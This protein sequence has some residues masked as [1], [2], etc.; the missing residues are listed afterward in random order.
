MRTKEI[1]TKRGMLALISCI[2]LLLCM[3]CA[4]C[5]DKSDTEGY[6]DARNGV[7]VVSEYVALEGEEV[8][9]AH[10][11]GFFIGKEGE[12]PQYLITNYHVIEDYLYYGAGMN[13]TYQAPDGT[14]YSLKSYLR[15]YFD[16][17]NYVEAYVEDYDQVADIALL[18]LE[19]PTDQRK[20]LKICSPT[21]DMIG[22]TIYAIGFPGL[23]DNSIIDATSSW[24]LSD[25]TITTGVINRL[26]TSS[27][28]GVK[29]IQTDAVLQAGNSGGPMVNEKGSV[30]GVN[31][32]SV[33]NSTET[34]YYAVNIDEVTE[35]LDFRNISYSREEESASGLP[36]NNLIFVIVAAVVI[37]AVI[38]I[39]VLVKNKKDTLKKEKSR[40]T[41]QTQ[42]SAGIPETAPTADTVQNPKDS[43]YRLQS[44][45]GALEGRRF[46]IRTDSPLTLGRNPEFCNV[47]YPANTAGVSGKHC[48][49]WYD[50]G[51]IYIND[52]GS[53][54]G[55]FIAPGR[56][57]AANQPIQIKQG[58]S[59]YLGSENEAMVLIKK[60]VN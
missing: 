57:L 15:V 7:A 33:G 26:V 45:S 30:V 4:G 27:G 12:N 21:E 42:E 17:D 6:K 39:A 5:S 59:F 31:V 25:T 49:I 50:N 18:K 8:G 1:K 10:G 47:V 44:V 11:S 3:I 41:Q 36:V 56:K 35:M 52:L 32:M 43:G 38:L 24:G 58:D 13:A 37:V 51:M 9:I 40:N 19:N 60:G 54:H 28:S 22:S 34:T 55:T 16:S 20:A 46:M 2:C 29:N 53:S 48:Q 23:S 14:K